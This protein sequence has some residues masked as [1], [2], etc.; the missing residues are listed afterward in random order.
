MAHRGRLSVLAH[1]LGRSVES[2]LAE[3]EGAK[4]LEQVKAI[5][6]MPHSRHRRREVPPRRR[7]AVLHP[8]GRGGQGAPVPEPEPPRVRR[9]GRHR[10]RP[11]RPD[12]ALGPDASPQPHV[13]V[14]L[15]LHGDAAFPGQGVVAETLNLQSLDGYSTGGTIHLITDNQVGFTTDPVDDRS[16]PYAGDMAKGFNCPIIHVNAD[17]V[18]ACIAA[19]RLAMAYRER[20]APRRRHRPDRLPPLRPQRD[21]RARLHAA[22][23]GGADQG[24]PAGLGDLRRAAGQGGRGLAR[25][26][27]QPRRGETLR[28]SCQATLKEPARED[29]GRRLRGPELDRTR[30]RRA[31]PDEEPRGRDRGLGEAPAHAQRGAAQG[32]RQLHHPPQAAQAAGEADRDPRGGRRSSTATPRRSRSPRC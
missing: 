14:P 24:A 32:S 6:A 11:R 13:A 5:T 16:T 28:P 18:E 31:R 26:R 2:I 19:T 7:G 3:F 17:D 25:R 20:F 23:D 15:L 22:E 9:P 4:A 29:G 21:R 1:N 12:R 30:H 27:R 10:R 8:R